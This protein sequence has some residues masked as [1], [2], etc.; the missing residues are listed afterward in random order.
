MSVFIELE[1]R[2]NNTVISNSSSITVMDGQKL[3]FDC[4]MTPRFPQNSSVKWESQ[5][6]GD[7]AVHWRNDKSAFSLEMYNVSTRHNGDYICKVKVDQI[8]IDITEHIFVKGMPF[9]TFK[10]ALR[11]ISILFPQSNTTPIVYKSLVI[12]LL[13]IIANSNR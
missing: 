1:I 7:R 11:I 10:V 12:Q 5:S 13:S 2:Y 8:P 6:M 3:E 9:F 4:V